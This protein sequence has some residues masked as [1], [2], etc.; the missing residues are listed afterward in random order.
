MAL[1]LISSPEKLDIVLNKI[2]KEVL[3]ARSRT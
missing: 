1:A 3:L 2:A